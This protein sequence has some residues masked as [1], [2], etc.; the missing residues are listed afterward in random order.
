MEQGVF[1]DLIAGAVELWAGDRGQPWGGLELPVFI[2]HESNE[3]GNI[4]HFHAVIVEVELKVI[5]IVMFSIV[6]QSTMVNG[7]CDGSCKRFY[8]NIVERA[9]A[10]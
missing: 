9:T 6:S 2:L 10:L 4:L 5:M 1:C 8:W 3:K 7:E